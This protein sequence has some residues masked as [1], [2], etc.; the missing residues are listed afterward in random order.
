MKKATYE[1]AACDYAAKVVSRWAPQIKTEVEGCENILGLV[2][3]LANMAA[4]IIAPAGDRSQRRQVRAVF[5]DA[6]D[7]SIAR[8]VTAREVSEHDMH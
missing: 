5:D 2:V 3:A 7:Q 1:A 8:F 4:M 6:L